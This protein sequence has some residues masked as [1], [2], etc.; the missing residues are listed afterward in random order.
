MMRDTIR[1]KAIKDKAAVVMDEAV[2]DRDGRPGDTAEKEANSEKREE[3][4][5]DR[6]G[7]DLDDLE[8]LRARRREQMKKAQEKRQKYAQLGHGQYEEI[9]EE[10]FLKTVTASERSI[11]H[12]YHRH[13]E[14]SK[15]MDMH[16]GRCAKKFFGTRFVKLDAEKAPFFVEKLK[17]RTL[18]CVV[19]FVDGVAVGRQMGFDGLGGDE[20]STAQL[21]WRLKEFGGIEED[22]GPEDDIEG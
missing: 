11:V 14:R 3:N 20:F 13:F 6:G 2:G 1:E 5:E 15:I 21:A 9:V 7:N 10:D 16:L 8:V 4:D 22:F 18:P 19:V 17:V 12:F